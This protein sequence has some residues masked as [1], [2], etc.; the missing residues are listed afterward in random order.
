MFWPTPSNTECKFIPFSTFKVSLFLAGKISPYWV[1]YLDPHTIPPIGWT[2]IKHW[3]TSTSLWHK[4]TILITRHCSTI[5]HTANRITLSFN[6]MIRKDSMY[7]CLRLWI[8]HLSD[9]TSH[10]P[11]WMLFV[12]TCIGQIYMHVEYI[13]TFVK[14]YY[15]DLSIDLYWYR[16]TFYTTLGQKLLFYTKSYFFLKS[17]SASTIK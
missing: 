10:L 12:S 13:R 15:S 17:I 1:T 2:L 5:F 8:N 7:C 11:V 6:A 16:Y 14:K 3:T 4:T 9:N